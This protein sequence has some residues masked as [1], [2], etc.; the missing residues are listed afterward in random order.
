[1]VSSSVGGVKSPRFF[2]GWVI[3]ACV[4]VANF[5]TVS[6]NPLVFAFFLDSMSVDLD[7]KR[8][9]L[10]WGI[11]IRM[12][13]GGLF[14][15]YLGRIVDRHGTR[16]PGAVAGLVV[17]LVLIGFAFTSN[18]WIMFGLFFI[19]GLTGFSIFGGNMLTMVPPASW[20]VAKRGR[21]L[22]I[23]TSGQLFGTA[24]FAIAAALLIEAFGWRWAW[25]IFG[26]VAIVGVV[27]PY[28]LL[29]R[30]RPEDMG[31]LP[32]GAT[33]LPVV[34]VTS[35]V[36]S[37]TPTAPVASA[38]H[39]EEPDF[40][41]AE[42]WRTP[43]LWANLAATT[44]LMVAIS[45]FLLFRNHYWTTLGFSPTLIAIGVALDPFSFAIANIAMGFFAERVPI[46]FTGVI[47][48]VW[49]GFGMLPLTLGMT[50]P[51]SVVL[52]NVVW[53]IGS[54]TTSVFQTMMIPDYFGRTNQGAIRGSIT[55]IMV[56]VSALGAPLGGYLLDA[57][58]SYI[59]FFWGI[60]LA[61][62]VASASFFFQ[63]PPKHAP[64]ATDPPTRMPTST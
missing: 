44:L 20:F 50:W 43:V 30:R 22:S 64:A 17:G 38:T 31:L 52:H 63:K 45:P 33:S 21:A 36:A 48:G 61:V 6:I 15:P 57:G 8:S 19:S 11:T 10:V 9:T 35:A 28:A 51:G 23:A 39:R 46:R 5:V 12:I 7:V 58:V 37:P 27:P 3:I 62:T 47:G 60:F 53:G 59:A 41:V 24:T 25:A 1:M 2:Y 55:P 18:I 13:S 54:G 14:A 42:A 29:M 40:T 32:D 56:T 49:R 16:W 26:I 34:E 4:W